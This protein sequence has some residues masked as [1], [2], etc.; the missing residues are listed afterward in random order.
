MTRILPWNGFT[1]KQKLA[2]GRVLTLQLHFLMV[3]KM[4]MLKQFQL[5]PP[6]RDWKEKL[7]KKRSWLLNLPILP[8]TLQHTLSAILSPPKPSLAGNKSRR[9]GRSRDHRAWSC[10]IP[11]GKCNSS[12]QA[13]FRMVSAY[14]KYRGNSPNFTTQTKPINT[15]LGA[16]SHSWYR[17]LQLILWLF[18]PYIWSVGSIIRTLVLFVYHLPFDLL[19]ISWQP[20]L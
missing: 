14:W 7:A 3:F 6:A 20:S 2:D 17:F 11:L 16:F 19:I 12:S 1:A 5:S 10:T 8:K 15:L 4:E 18:N 13:M 9:L